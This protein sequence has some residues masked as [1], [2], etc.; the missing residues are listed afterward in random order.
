[1]KSNVPFNINSIVLFNINIIL[2]NL[3]TLPFLNHIKLIKFLICKNLFH[4]STL[5]SHFLI[6]LSLVLISTSS[7]VIS[8]LILSNCFCAS[9]LFFCTLLILLPV[10]SLIF[11]SQFLTSLFTSSAASAATL[12][13]TSA[14][15]TR[16]SS[17]PTYEGQI[18]SVSF[19]RQTLN[20]KLK[21]LF[22][23]SLK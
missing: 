11:A 3:T 18:N 19:G 4:I 6:S 9:S 5:S 13:F 12:Y 15:F 21:W 17:S 20:E 2:L 23:I 7:L 16:F 14:A 1:M 22:K 10:I 8:F